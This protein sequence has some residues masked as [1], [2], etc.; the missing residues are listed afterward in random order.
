MTNKPAA[1]EA[2]APHR[3]L[4][5]TPSASVTNGRTLLGFLY[6]HDHQVAALTPDRILIGEFVDRSA[7]RRA[8]TD[9]HAA[10]QVQTR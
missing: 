3:Y 5:C 10:P 4:S 6:D 1:R 2:Q 7:A 8:I 9:H